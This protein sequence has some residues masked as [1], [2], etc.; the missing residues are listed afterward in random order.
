M[1]RFVVY[2]Q[3]VI[4]LMT[5]LVMTFY[6]YILFKGVHSCLNWNVKTSLGWIS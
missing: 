6:W 2:C 4:L 5:S 1:L 3:R